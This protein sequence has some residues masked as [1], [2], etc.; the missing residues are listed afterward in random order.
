MYLPSQRTLILLDSHTLS[1]IHSPTHLHNYFLP[2]FL[3]S[4]NLQYLLSQLM[5][6]FSISARKLEQSTKFLQ[7]LTLTSIYLP[8]AVPTFAEPFQLLF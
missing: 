5:T 3:T 2:S 1:L 7:T 4:P 6:L 8:T